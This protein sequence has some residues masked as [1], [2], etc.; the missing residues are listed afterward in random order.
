MNRYIQTLN[1]YLADHIPTSDA[2]DIHSVFD[3]LHYC[4]MDWNPIHT[5]TIK[6]CFD[7]ISPVMD[8]LSRSHSDLLFQK[9][10]ELCEEYE[11]QVFL[12]GLYLGAKFTAELSLWD[13]D[14]HGAH[15]ASQ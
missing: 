3:F 13:T 12:D 6:S 11:R 15:G 8:E 4:Y 14:C 1:D 2:M 10:C 5:D 7:D 9:V